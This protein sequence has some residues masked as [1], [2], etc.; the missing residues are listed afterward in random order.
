MVCM[1]VRIVKS[2]LAPAGLC[3]AVLFLPIE[4]RSE[5][6]VITRAGDHPKYAVEIEPH[7]LAAFLMPVAQNGFGLGARFSIPIVENGFIGSINN[8]VAIGFGADWVRYGGCYRNWNH[9][10]WDY[11]CPAFDRF[12]FPVVLQ[13]NFFLSTHFSVFAEP[14]IALHYTSWG[15][16][17]ACY[18][19]D[20]QG[21]IHYE[22]CGPYVGNR[23]D[24]DPF[25]L[26]LGGRYHISEKIALTG[27]IGYPYFSF[28]VSFMP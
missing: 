26:A 13:W 15:G 14:G 18:W 5:E 10:S 23:F 25:I 16:A 28:G 20:D 21:R 3:L 12:L 24:W 6:S 8:S 22:R 9:R 1:K 2:S 19:Y 11:G 4:A 7:A 27:R 17:D